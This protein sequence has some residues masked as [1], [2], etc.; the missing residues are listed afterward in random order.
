MFK[1]D[2]ESCQFGMVY[3]I[4]VPMLCFLISGKDCSKIASENHLG[5]LLNS[6]GSLNTERF[7]VCLR[8]N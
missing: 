8:I 6:A 2:P 3:D 5:D 7:A 4:C 1:Q